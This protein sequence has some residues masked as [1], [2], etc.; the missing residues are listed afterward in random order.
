LVAVLIDLSA[1]PSQMTGRPLAA[2]TKTAD[3][4]RLGRFGARVDRVDGQA[5]RLIAQA[6]VDPAMLTHTPMTGALHALDFGSDHPSRVS[7]TGKAIPAFAGTWPL[8]TLL[9][10]ETL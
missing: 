6:S 5:E 9:R 1:S 4:Q 2:G 10:D 3:E 8:E 7:K